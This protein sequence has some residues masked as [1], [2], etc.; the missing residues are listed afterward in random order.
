MK[1][2]LLL[3]LCYVLVF[4]LNACA[5][6]I[7][8]SNP[9]SKMGW[10]VGTWQGT[11]NGGPFYES[12]KKKNDSVLVNFTIE[13]SK[14]DTVIKEHGVMMYGSKGMVYIG[15]SA[16]WKLT[17]VNDTLIV[18]SNDTLK[19]ANKITWSYSKN[20]H[21][22]TVIENPK[23]VVRYDMVRVGWLDRYV[24]NFIHKKR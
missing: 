16:Q 9:V 4:S 2:K 3:L 23:N 18:L 1:T 24:D 15:G 11:Y 19:F 20:G 8:S 21:W 17:D 22:L 13:V 7:N 14:G 10:I 12:W 5:Q 6:K